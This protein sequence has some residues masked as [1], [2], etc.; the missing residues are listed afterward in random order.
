MISILHIVCK[1]QIIIYSYMYA[2]DIVLS[3]CLTIVM[4]NFFIF[5][6]YCNIF[7]SCLFCVK[8]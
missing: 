3:V 4:C 6:A 5:N 2:T 7:Y 1:I 8:K